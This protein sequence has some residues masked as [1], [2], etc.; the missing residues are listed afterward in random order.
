MT[1]KKNDLD[2]LTRTSIHQTNPFNL[3]SLFQ[4]VEKIRKTQPLIHNITNL[5]VMQTVANVLLALG[6]L[7]LMAHAKEEVETMIQNAQAFVINIGT[8]DSY[9]L[10]CI[11]QGQYAALKRGIPI[12]LD[13][14]G[15]GS[16]FY[17]TQAAL[18]I[19]E[20]GVDI[21]RGNAS[22]IMALQDSSIKTKGVDTLQP[23]EH[24]ISSAYALAKKYECIVVVSGKT[25]FIVRSSQHVAL[26]YG[27]ALLTKVTG[28]GCALTAMMGSFLSV[29]PDKLRACVHTMAF[30]GLVSEY[31]EK[32]SNGPASFCTNLLDLFYSAQKEDVQHLLKP[33][34]SHEH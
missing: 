15:A 28:M 32:K 21:I 19:I 12:L 11:Q 26:R 3:T 1:L 34:V 20:R 24:A 4:D 2:Q 23:S 13:P 22:E 25:D 16:S 5:V 9:W 6:A 14:V 30:M 29:N 10:S 7:P 17:R 31:A 18:T 27:S 8:L 33:N